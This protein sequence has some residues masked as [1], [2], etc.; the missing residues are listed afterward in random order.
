M[1]F[2]FSNSVRILK[3]KRTISKLEKTLL[4]SVSSNFSL[5]KL[6]KYYYSNDNKDNK[7]MQ[8]YDFKEKS[9]PSTN[10]LFNRYNF[11]EEMI[12]NCKFDV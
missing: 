12:E 7:Y 9:T 2:S 1:K 3:N 5:F 10:P 4:K 6:N 8:E 11:T